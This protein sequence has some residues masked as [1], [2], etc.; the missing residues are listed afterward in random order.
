M[1]VLMKVPLLNL[2][3]LRIDRR[4]LL[5]QRFSYGLPLHPTRQVFGSLVQQHHGGIIV[6]GDDPVA[7]GA[8]GAS[9]R[10]CSAAPVACA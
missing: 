9:R 3:G 7:D 8:Q 5:T 2:L 6:S 1:A 10:S 4:E